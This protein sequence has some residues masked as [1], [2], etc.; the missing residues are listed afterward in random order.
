MTPLSRH[1]LACVPLVVGAG[2][3]TQADRDDALNRAAYDETIDQLGE[4]GVLVPAFDEVCKGA[5][6]ISRF[7]R[8]FCEVPLPGGPIK[9]VS[10]DLVGD[11]ATKK[12]THRVHRAE[13][14]YIRLPKRLPAMPELCKDMHTQLEPFVEALWSPADAARVIRNMRRG[15]ER[16]VVERT[17]VFYYKGY[18]ATAGLCQVGLHTVT[19]PWQ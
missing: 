13:V 5:E 1:V 7:P 4:D 2:C 11:L 6:E 12:R 15:V 3:E 17:E 9:W 14:T 10:L 18:D 19:D 8:Y 16:F